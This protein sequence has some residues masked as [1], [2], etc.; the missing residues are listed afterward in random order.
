MVTVPVIIAGGIGERFWPLSRSSSPKQLLSLVSSKTMIEETLIRCQPLC[1]KNT[2]PL[3]MTGR[4]MADLM[5]KKLPQELV[6]DRIIEPIG[7]NTAPAVL[8]AAAWIE[9]K[10]NGP[11]VMA[12]MSAD[13]YIQP[14]KA[15]LAAVRTAAGF[16]RENDALVTFGVEPTRPESGYGYLHIG[17]PVLSAGSAGIYKVKRFIEKPSVSKARSLL[18]SN[19]YLWN[20]GMFVWKTSV[21]I[22][23]FG[24][25]MPGM[26]KKIEEVKIRGFSQKS[27]DDYYFNAEAI[28]IDYGIMEKSDK[29]YAV[30]GDFQWDDVGSWEALSR[31]YGSDANGTTAFGKN[32]MHF[33]CKDGIIYNNSDTL[34]VA[35]DLD[36]IAIVNTGDALLVCSRRRLP[37]L[38][39][40]LKIIKE[41]KNINTALF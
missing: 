29:V 30:A 3:I 13:H 19:S 36:G 5:K 41:N 6:Y 33:E 1:S 32:V 31:I 20:C 8:M 16:A 2:K 23:E 4:V 15:F 38:K 12:V 39:K 34:A 21:I 7:K 9:Y 35:I 18:K 40:Y 27:I 14:D 11:A 28:S 24:K 26:K 17:E 25:H 22:D 10:Y 37:D